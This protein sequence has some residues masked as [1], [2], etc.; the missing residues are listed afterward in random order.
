M[1]SKGAVRV[2]LG[3]LSIQLNKDLA[4]LVQET[5]LLCDPQDLICSTIVDGTVSLVQRTWEIVLYVPRLW[6]MMM[7][8]DVLEWRHLD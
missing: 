5:V 3:S 8:I 6:M 2:S 7:M 1:D 4:R